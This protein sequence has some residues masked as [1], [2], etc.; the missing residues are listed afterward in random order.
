MASG[1]IL[2]LRPIGPELSWSKLNMGQ[3]LMKL[4][5][6]IWVVGCSIL[7]FGVVAIKFRSLGL[8]LAPAIFRERPQTA[9]LQHLRFRVRTSLE[10]ELPIDW[11]ALLKLRGRIC[12]SFRK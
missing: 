7:P 6:L 12:G 5:F 11:T 10:V 9:G 3:F 2:G 1:L 4:F 8:S